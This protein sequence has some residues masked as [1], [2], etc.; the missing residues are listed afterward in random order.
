MPHRNAIVRLWLIFDGPSGDAKIVV[1]S[2]KAPKRGRRV[3]VQAPR[4]VIDAGQLWVLARK[5]PSDVV[6]AVAADAASLETRKASLGK[7]AAQY[8]IIS[9][10]VV[11]RSPSDET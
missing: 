10:P 1:A 7:V 5:N 2:R 8:E 4:T 3:E 6:L 9:V 11:E